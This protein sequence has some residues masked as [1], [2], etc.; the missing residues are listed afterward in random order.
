M[1]ENADQNNSEHGHFLH[2]ETL[3]SSS[4]KVL[5]TRLTP[6]KQGVKKE[7]CTTK[8]IEFKKNYDTVCSIVK[9]TKRTILKSFQ[10]LFV[11]FGS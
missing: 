4:I 11:N 3:G 6:F 5:W 9:P 7:I 10:C 8:L 1:R 2:S